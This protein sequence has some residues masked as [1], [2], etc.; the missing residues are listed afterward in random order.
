MDNLPYRRFVLELYLGLC[1][2]DIDI[3]AGWVYGQVQEI[4]DLLPLGDKTVEGFGHRLGEIGMAHV[5]AIDKEIL[6][7]A[8]LPG[9]LRT[10]HKPCYPYQSSIHIHRHK[11]VADLLAENINNTPAEV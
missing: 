2:T 6:A 9:R 5:S 4:R 3:N 1:G 7:C 10:A 11:V 8:F